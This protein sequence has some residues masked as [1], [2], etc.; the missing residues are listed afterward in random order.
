MIPA[1]LVLAGIVVA[2][3][4][5]AMGWLAE[6][7]ATRLRPTITARRFRRIVVALLAVA[8]TAGFVVFSAD[9]T[10]TPFYVGGCVLAGMLVGSSGIELLVGRIDRCVR[11]S[12]WSRRVDAWSLVSWGR[13]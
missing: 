3:P 9:G 5:S 13:R 8:L 6:V 7:I 4:L 1:A 10:L 11:S 12:R 2:V